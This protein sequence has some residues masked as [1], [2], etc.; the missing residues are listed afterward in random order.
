M[1]S[2]LHDQLD[3]LLDQAT[4]S[5]IHSAESNYPRYVTGEDL[6]QEGQLLAQAACSI[7]SGE[8]Q[9]RGIAFYSGTFVAAYHL[10]RKTL[11]NYPTASHNQHSLR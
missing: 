6:A 11:A 8:A 7:L 10:H 2:S 1:S 4:Q 9:E 5:A 3:N